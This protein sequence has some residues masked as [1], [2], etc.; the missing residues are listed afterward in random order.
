MLPVAG[1]IA[2]PLTSQDE[3]DAMLLYRQGRF[4]TPF[5]LLCIR[6]GRFLTPSRRH[7]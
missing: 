7:R 1:A 2:S 6:V 3:Q 5:R 4:V